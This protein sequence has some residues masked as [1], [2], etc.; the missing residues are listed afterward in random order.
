MI[1]VNT[2][3]NIVY[4]TTYENGEVVVTTSNPS[5]SQ[6]AIT[7]ED[8]GVSL[9]TRG[10]VNEVD[11][12]GSGVAATR[13]GNKLTVTITSGGGAGTVTSVAQTVPSILS[14]SG[15]P[16]TTSGTLAISLATQA[17]NQ[18]FSGPTSGGAA[19][20]TF[21]AL[22]AADLA[23]GIVYALPMSAMTGASILTNQPNTEEY[24]LAT[25]TRL[26]HKFDATAFNFVRLAFNVIV[27]SASPN[28]P[29]AYI[30]FKTSYSSGDAVGTFTTVG[31]GAGTEIISLTSVAA[32]TTDW[33]AMP[34]GAKADVFWC[35]ATNGGDATA[36]PQHGS[37]SIQFKV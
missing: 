4:V 7:F 14:V 22:V 31:S 27:G 28:T 12:V 30:K 3:S 25:S 32:L 34:A 15:S 26:I 37:V 6:A 5:P 19:T 8:E 16:I 9:G 18:V 36:D 10:T 21:R 35:V 13:S 33:I 11:F 29:R 17:A 24:L 1:Y 23:V 2:L 20:P